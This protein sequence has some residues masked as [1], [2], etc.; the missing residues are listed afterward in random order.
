[1][2]RIT[3]MIVTHHRVSTLKVGNIDK[4]VGNILSKD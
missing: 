2:R 3:D 4:F 1:M